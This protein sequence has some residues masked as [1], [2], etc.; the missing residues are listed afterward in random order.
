MTRI[1]KLQSVLER[2]RINYALIFQNRDLYYFAAT[3]QDGILVVPAAGEPTLLVRRNYERAKEETSVPRVVEMGSLD[4]L[5]ELIAPQDK[6]SIGIE[7][8]V[9]PAVTYQ[10]LL[11]LFPGT[12]F[13]DISPS[14]MAIRMV[15]EAGE[16]VVLKK[17]AEINDALFLRARQ[18]IRPGMS[19]LELYAELESTVRRLGDD[20]LG[21]P[22]GFNSL[23]PNQ[24]SSGSQAALPNRAALPFGGV[25]L[26]PAAPAGPSWRR[27]E[28]DDAVVVD[29]VSCYN[30]YLSDQT[31][32]YF[33][34]KPD[35]ELVRAYRTCQEIYRDVVTAM[36]PG[37]PGKELYQLAV[38]MAE[39]AGYEHFLGIGKY[40]VRYVGHG[41]GL[42]LTEQPVLS[43]REET[44]LQ[45]N[46]VL[47]VEPKIALPGKGLVGIENTLRI[48][49]DGA[50]PLTG[51]EAEDIFM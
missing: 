51:A 38:R 31:R 27:L 39:S 22:R 3:M 24:I 4:Q 48:T 37:V 40:K 6:A 29:W 1:A 34:G 11:T 23:P 13:S 7:A 32:T 47:T 5:R 42:E 18:V 9:L 10:R 35:V 28:R 2:E 33:L 45:E 12:Q 46:M 49:G 44:L 8:D 14:V 36:R 17:S 30:G 19:E 43:Y 21:L 26:S 15:K 41:L 50:Q 20:R 16:I 25:G